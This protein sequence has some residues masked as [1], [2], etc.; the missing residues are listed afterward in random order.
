MADRLQP[1]EG[2]K[3]YKTSDGLEFWMGSL[4]RGAPFQAPTIFTSDPEISIVIV[5]GTEACEKSYLMRYFGTTMV[6]SKPSAATIR[7]SDEIDRL[8]ARNP[9]VDLVIKW[10]G[11][12]AKWLENIIDIEG[13][14]IHD[15]PSAQKFKSREEQEEMLRLFC[16]LMQWLGFGPRIM[17]NGFFPED[18]FELEPQVVGFDVKLRAR[19]DAG[20]FVD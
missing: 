4:V 11:H 14:R 5:P 13:V 9:G 19:L 1:P 6:F 20:G 7:H 10:I 17:K 2:V 12:T 16:E 8:R 15:I 3:V 18:R